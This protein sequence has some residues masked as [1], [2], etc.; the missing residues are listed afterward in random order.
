[1]QI[2][3]LGEEILLNDPSG[4]GKRGAATFSEPITVIA[5]RMP[6]VSVAP[7]QH[8]AP[9]RPLKVLAL[10]RYDRAGSSSRYRFYQFLPALERA[11][12]HVTMSPLLPPDYIAN[13]FR[14]RSI[15]AWGVA[16]SFAS[17]LLQLSRARQ[18]HLLWIEKELLPYLPATVERWLARE[19]ISYVVDYDDA[20]FHQYDRHARWVVRAALGRKIDVVMA[21]A[22]LVTPGN[23]YLATRARAAGARRIEIIPTV[24]DLEQYT[25][26]SEP[27]RSRQTLV[28][29]WIGSPTTQHY[30]TELGPVLAAFAAERSAR[31]VAIGAS[32]GFA[33]AGIQTSVVPWSEA[34]ENRDLAACDV[35]IMPLTEEPWSR[36]KCG[37][38]LI[39]C[40]ASSLPVVGSRTEANAEIIAHGQN[41]FIAATAKEWLTQL[42][43]L[44]EDP[45]LR[46]RMGAAGRAHIEQGYSLQAIAPRIAGLLRSVRS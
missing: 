3:S 46:R 29:G 12:I 5:K 22:T 41:G 45:A 8:Q 19:Q 4:A 38:K 36:G 11:G 23:V 14:G 18:F 44:A 1:M 25:R 13:L 34:T 15:T 21:R 42:R 40:M 10:T 26:R 9:E 39:Q 35:G 28:I 33:V 37:L 30:L 27:D 7:D 20:T 2:G 43:T 6:E 17:R 16:K 32:P 24:V 31:L